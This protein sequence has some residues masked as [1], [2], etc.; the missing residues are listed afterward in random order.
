MK[1]QVLKGEV[2]ARVEKLKAQAK[3]GRR[4]AHPLVLLDLDSTLYE[5]GPRTYQIL[6][7][8]VETSESAAGFP[9]CATLCC[10]PSLGM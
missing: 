1:S 7:E 8:W 6:R 3:L 10:E 4:E 9:P 5:V 2:A